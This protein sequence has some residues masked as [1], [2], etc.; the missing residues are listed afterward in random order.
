[1]IPYQPPH[2]LTKTP[3]QPELAD[4]IKACMAAGHPVG[5]VID[6]MTKRGY[7]PAAAQRWATEHMFPASTYLAQP[8]RIKRTGSSIKTHDREVRVAMWMRDPIVAILDNVLSHDE[9]DKLIELS[10]DRLQRSTTVN[11]VT[12]GGDVSDVRTS[13]GTYFH[14]CESPFIAA[15]DRRLADITQWPIDRAEGMQILRY[16]DGAEYK[17]HFDYFDPAEPGSKPYLV[18]GGQRVSTMVLYLSDVEEGGET[19]FPALN[20]EVMPRKGSAAYFEYCN[21]HGQLDQRSLHGGLPVTKGV[22]WIATKWM[23]ERV[24]M[25][26]VPEPSRA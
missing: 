18:L 21:S 19:T 17:A 15:I 3:I 25:P 7:D 26:P 22:K 1:M 13:S 12:G 24:F 10:K 9:C 2:P 5:T 16:S 11:N 6:V 23:R 20:L 14:V 4:W 8:P